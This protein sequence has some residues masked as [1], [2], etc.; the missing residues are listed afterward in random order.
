MARGAFEDVR[1]ELVR[2]VSRIVYEHERIR[3]GCRAE[4]CRGRLRGRG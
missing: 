3:A 4:G 1:D 2:R